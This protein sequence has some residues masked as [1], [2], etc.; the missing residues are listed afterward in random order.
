MRTIINATPSVPLYTE[1]KQALVAHSLVMK[2]AGLILFLLI[3]LPAW[4]TLA[5]PGHE[6]SAPT[7]FAAESDGV[8]MGQ[9]SAHT[10]VTTRSSIGTIAGSPLVVGTRRCESGRGWRRR[11]WHRSGCLN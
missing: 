2:E 1:N 3:M 8:E 10:Q 7:S 11:C 4:S 9:A 5:H 6:P